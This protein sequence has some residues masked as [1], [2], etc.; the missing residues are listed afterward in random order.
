[1]GIRCFVLIITFL[2]SSASFA[3]TFSGNQFLKLS[4]NQ[5][6][7]YFLGVLDAMKQ[8][9]DM[10]LEA[11][12]MTESEFDQFFES[13]IAE[14]PV[15]QHLAIVELWLKNHP[16]RW[17]EPAIKLIFDAER[18][19]CTATDANATNSIVKSEVLNE[20]K[21]PTANTTNSIVKPEVLNVAKSPNASYLIVTTRTPRPVTPIIIQQIDGKVISQAQSSLT[22]ARESYKVEP[23]V[24]QIVIAP[25]ANLEKSQVV[26]IDVKPGMDYYLGWHESEPAIWKEE[27]N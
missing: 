15:R 13:C 18:H 23:G 1:M 16:N 14:R 26:T 27:S 24:H 17:H 20:P 10:Y 7:W 22:T 2:L 5:K 19:S 11:N 25:K 9:R 6:G 8:T 3:E 12:E 4:A 21:L